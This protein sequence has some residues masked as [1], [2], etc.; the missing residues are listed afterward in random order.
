MGRTLT[1]IWVIYYPA[2]ILLIIKS[3]TYYIQLHVELIQIDC[4]MDD[5]LTYYHVPPGT[6]IMYIPKEWIDSEKNISIFINRTYSLDRVKVDPVLTDLAL[7]PN[8]QKLLNS[9]TTI[10]VIVNNV[11][12]CAWSGFGRDNRTVYLSL[13]GWY[14]HI[15]KNGDVIGIYNYAI[16]FN[17]MVSSIYGHFFHD[18][19]TNLLLVP[20]YFLDQAMIIVRIELAVAQDLLEALNISRNRVIRLKDN[21]WIFAK[22]YILHYNACPGLSSMPLMGNLS[23]HLR[24]HFKL[25]NI[26]PT[27]YSLY[28]RRSGGRSIQNFEE[29]VNL[30][31]KQYSH[32]NWTI[33]PDE[34]TTVRD[35]ANIWSKQKF[36]FGLVG[37]G[38]YHAL[39]MK[40]GQALCIGYSHK[41]AIEYLGLFGTMEFYGFLFSLPEMPIF[42]WHSSPINVSRTANMIGIGLQN[43]ETKS[44]NV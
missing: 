13:A 36:V 12:V 33:I 8:N 17:H 31:K 20:K 38:L 24:R 10:Q 4:Q 9:I 32:I 22:H 19:M 35:A 43:Y 44:V 40:P 2:L 11:Y 18:L 41:N 26:E 1:Q 34:N 42:N 27:E 37:S 6:A 16:S 3:Y 5:I 29:L 23:D 7:T 25:E 28:N 15:S 14:G 21:Q 30:T 39:F